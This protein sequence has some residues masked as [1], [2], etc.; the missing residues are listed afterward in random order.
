VRALEYL[1]YLLDPKVQ[2]VISTP[3]EDLMQIKVS[4]GG[5]MKTMAMNLS[6]AEISNTVEVLDRDKASDLPK[7]IVMR[8]Q[9]IAR[10]MAYEKILREDVGDIAGPTLKE[11]DAVSRANAMKFNLAVE[12]DR[13]EVI[14]SGSQVKL[15]D[16]FSPDVRLECDK[17]KI[18]NSGLKKNCLVSKKK[19]G[20]HRNVKNFVRRLN[21]VGS[22]GSRDGSSSLDESHIDEM[23]RIPMDK[24]VT[25]VSHRYGEKTRIVHPKHLVTHKRNMSLSN[26]SKNPLHNTAMSKPDTTQEQ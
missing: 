5:A 22:G 10:D 23:I 16:L 6:L 3:F 15:K 24:F 14:C 8:D 1:N 19:E 25:P 18:V 4:M 7:Q 2:R 12:A 13:L 11:M 9:Y 26:Y 20:Q 17:K 21:E